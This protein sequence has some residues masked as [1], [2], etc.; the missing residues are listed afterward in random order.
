MESFDNWAKGVKLDPEI[1]LEIPSDENFKV[2]FE[3]IQST[4]S[5]PEW[6][7]DNGS[8]RFTC[9]KNKFPDEIDSLCDDARHTLASKYSRHD[10]DNVNQDTDNSGD[11]EEKKAYLP[12]DTPHQDHQHAEILASALVGGEGELD[13]ALACAMGVILLLA[14]HNRNLLLRT[15]L[16]SNKSERRLIINSLLLHLCVDPEPLMFHWQVGFDSS[17]KFH[18]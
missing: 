8:S 5:V 9:L 11:C 4:K 7:L 14:W 13:I 3:L 16:G 10:S 2:L 12:D 15:T 17:A 1:I 6:V 18:D